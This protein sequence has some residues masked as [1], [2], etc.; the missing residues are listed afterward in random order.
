MG[1]FREYHFIINERNKAYES[2]DGE[3]N[4][5]DEYI[6]IPD[7]KTGEIRRVRKVKNI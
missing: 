3:L 4:D 6:E 2:K 5:G 7:I 1:M